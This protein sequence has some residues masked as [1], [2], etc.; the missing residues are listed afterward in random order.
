MRPRRITST[1]LCEEVDVSMESGDARGSKLKNPRKSGGLTSD[2]AARV[3]ALMKDAK[4]ESVAIDAIRPNRRNVRRHPAK[5]V[6]ILAESIRTLGFTNPVLVDEDGEILAGHGRYAAARSL[7][8]SE[9][10]IIRLMHLSSAEKRALAL[11]DN[12]IAELGSWDSDQLKETLAQLSDPSFDLSFDLDFTG[13]DTKEIHSIL[14]PAAPR[15]P[16]PADQLPDA[17]P[18]DQPVV[19]RVGDKWLCGG[20]VL[21]CADPLNAY[22]QELSTGGNP[23]VVALVDPFPSTTE[24]DLEDMAG[25]M[26]AWSERVAAQVCPGAM[27][28]WFTEWQQI[29]V[30]TEVVQP[31]I[32]APRDMV[33]WV[34]SDARPGTLYQSRYDQV[35]VF[36]MGDVPPLRAAQL[37]RGGRRRTNV[38][39]HPG[40][41]RD[42]HRRTG[43]KPVA[44]VI[45]ILKDC[46]ARGDIVLD[47]FAGS[48]TT[49]I[50]AERTRRCARLMER[51]PRWCDVIV[52][53]WE[54][55]T[56][57]AARH[58]ESSATF[59]EI[60]KERSSDGTQGEN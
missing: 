36:V 48:G 30:L 35:A 12:K 9:I 24:L 19:T 5:Q 25:H 42:P 34:R 52:R 18:S 29:G 59:A 13:F 2:E 44:F 40:G 7:G 50:A 6:A 54:K 57:V 8:L 27:I 33:V 53:R 1:A 49:M 20:H 38:W 11:A 3:L 41:D 46:S 23:A 10:L 21:V 14:Y 43:R 17:G 26:Q 22:F 31:V 45:D 56:K 16:D 15:R 28:Y 47:L 37:G 4:T 58:A 51:D 39:T 60:A 55:W 32:G